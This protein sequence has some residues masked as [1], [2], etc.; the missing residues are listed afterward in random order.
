MTGLAGHTS[1]G[2]GGIELSN[3]LSRLR[4][5]WGDGVPP[6]SP[7]DLGSIA[8]AQLIGQRNVAVRQSRMLADHGGE[9]GLAF[10]RAAGREEQAPQIAAQMG[11]RVFVFIR[12]QRQR[13]TQHADPG[14]GARWISACGILEGA[15]E[16]LDPVAEA[17]GA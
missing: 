16:I 15:A 11:D 9:R 7:S 1:P 3:P 5:R 17:L 14:L 2:C 6:S 4:G 10:F 13:V 8:T 12:E